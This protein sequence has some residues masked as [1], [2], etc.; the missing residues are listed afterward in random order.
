MTTAFEFCECVSSARITCKA[1]SHVMNLQ[2]AMGMTTTE[3][4]PNLYHTC[5]DMPSPRSRRY[6]KRLD[7]SGKPTPTFM[8]PS[9]SVL[10]VIDAAQCRSRLC[11]IPAHRLLSLLHTTPCGDGYSDGHV[12]REDVSGEWDT[13]LTWG[14]GRAGLRLA[15]Q[16][17][18][19]CC[20]G[21]GHTERHQV[22]WRTVL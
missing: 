3:L 11:G 8:R 14:P 18:D 1:R 19:P 21:T 17:S 9:G 22:H 13:Y 15:N 6:L 10:P 2:A 7:S 20:H 12:E 5:A 4:C 16:S